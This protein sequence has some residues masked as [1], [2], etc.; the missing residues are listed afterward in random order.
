MITYDM[1]MTNYNIAACK[2]N[3]IAPS[4]MYLYGT[5]YSSQA[6]RTLQ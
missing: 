3:P 1:S 2:M 4:I 6:R 5:I